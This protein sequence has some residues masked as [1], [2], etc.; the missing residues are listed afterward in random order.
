VAACLAQKFL[1]QFAL[2]CSD[3]KGLIL[4]DV[5]GLGCNLGNINLRFDVRNMLFLEI[6]ISVRL[7]FGVIITVIDVAKALGCLQPRDR[8]IP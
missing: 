1:N 2:F 8:L 6:V 5:T 7:C 3:I 4:I